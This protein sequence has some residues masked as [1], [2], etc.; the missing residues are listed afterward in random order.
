MKGAWRQSGVAAVADHL[1]H[2][3]GG[4]GFVGRARPVRL[5]LY[6]LALTFAGF[7]V[8]VAFAPS[9]PA[10]PAS[11]PAAAWFDGLIASASPYRGQVSGFLS[12][13]LPA[14]C[15][16]TAPPGA[17]AVAARRV[18]PSGGGLAPSGPQGNGSSAVW[19][20][21]ELLGSGG[22]VPPSSSSVGG[23]PNR[24]RAPAPGDATAAAVPSAV[25]PRD[26]RVRAS[27]AEA[28]HSAGSAAAEAKGGRDEPAGLASG[29][30]GSTQN[31][32]TAKGGVPVRIN[33]P[34][35]NAS[36]ADASGD[37]NGMRATARNA[38]GST[39]KL[40]GSGTAA[41]GNGTAVA[42]T[43]NQTA[44]AAAAAMDGN[45]TASPRSA[46]AAAG[47]NQTVLIQ[48][49]ADN[50]NNSSVASDGS[51]STAN[52]Q[53]EPTASPQGRSTSPVKDHPAA[54]GATPIANNSSA[55][56][57]KAAA[58]AGRRKKDDWVENLASCDMFYGNW[59]QD[60]SYP[61]Y[62]AGSCPHIDESFNCHLN[63]RPDKAYE[64][65]RWQPSGCRIPRLNPTD[66]LE[67]LRG[68]RLVFVGDSLNRN[69]WESLICIL[70]NSVKNKRKVFE[71]SGRREFKA[72]GSYSFLFQDYNC[73]VEFFRSPFLVQEWEMP[74]KNGKGTRE[75][76][77]L[78][79][80]DRASPRYKNADI[81]IFNTG[82]W[83]THDKTSLGKDYYQEGNRVY[84]ELDVHDAYR[85]ALNTWAKWVDSN[86]NTKKTT[87]FFRGYA[88]SHFSGGQ[89]NSGGSCDKETEPITNDQYLTPYPTKMSILEEVLGGM[90]TPVVYLNITRMTDYRK[91]AHPSV[92]RKQKLT[93]EEIKSPALYQDCSHWCLPG[94]PDSWN[95]LL[96]AHILVKQR[97][98]MQQ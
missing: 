40:G 82:H 84:S 97:H 41:S 48:A 50:K 24:D 10:P 83:W 26:D 49:P 96:Y 30:S 27:T 95:E 28:K 21:G 1:G 19:P 32:A 66:M 59:I 43:T 86:V 90:K 68:K 46:G 58:N 36:S 42:S 38:A 67:R 85:R 92:Y 8:F 88:A 17:V 12:S 7:A 77:R 22:G 13:L 76:L 63:G 94:V 31:I 14:N 64:R 73:S 60:D 81:I 23:V 3:G 25:A 33:V 61:L 57:V 80:V 62:P 71:V 29:G 87:V 20:R 78:D 44:S 5:C 9:L 70:R 39:H 79:I 15:S 91:E 56:L 69:M 54:Q 72:E 35:A 45:G 2:L 75:T 51:N 74:I 6:G 55:A 93:E 34:N 47:N 52:K 16:A 89:W 65:L 11:S 4:A 18:G 37:G 98:T 53:R